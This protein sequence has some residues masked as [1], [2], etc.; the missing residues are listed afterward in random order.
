MLGVSLLIVSL[1][2]FAAAGSAIPDRVAYTVA[3]LVIVVLLMLPWSAWESVFGQ[4]S[5]NFSTWIV[6]G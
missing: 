5:M 1:V 3:G 2:P 6:S 4:L